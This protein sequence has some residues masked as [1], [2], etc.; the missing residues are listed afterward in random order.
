MS[1]IGFLAKKRHGKDTAANYLVENYN[2]KKITFA[3]PLKDACKMLFGFTDEQLYGNL[4]EVKDE[5]WG[6]SPRTAFQYLGTDVFRKDVYKIMPHIKNNFW[7]Y[8]LK[9]K[10]ITEIKKNP[11]SKITIADVRFQNE[12]DIVHELGGIIIKIYRPNMKDTSNHIAENAIDNIKNY[13]VLIENTG[14]IKDFKNKIY[15]YLHKMKII[16]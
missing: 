4:K 2:Y 14:T 1:L 13:D 15:T 9:H 10:Y 5:F 3:G 8:K 6:I 11:K 16:T 12:V 7:V